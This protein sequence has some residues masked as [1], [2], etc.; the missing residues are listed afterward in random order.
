M[1]EI[2]PVPVAGFAAPFGLVIG[3]FLNVVVHRVP[4][5]ELVV[6]VKGW[7]RRR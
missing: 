2:P 1:T 5:G 4:R 6:E 7:A 3:S